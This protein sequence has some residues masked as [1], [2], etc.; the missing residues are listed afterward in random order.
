MQ[1]DNILPISIGI[2]IKSEQPQPAELPA[3]PKAQKPECVGSPGTVDLVAYSKWATAKCPPAACGT[4]TAAIHPTIE[5]FG[6]IGETVE[7]FMRGGVRLTLES[8]HRAKLIDEIG[9]VVFCAVWVLRAMGFEE[10][11]SRPEFLFDPA[12]TDELWENGLKVVLEAIRA[13][14]PER[15]TVAS[16][17][18]RMTVEP[19]FSLLTVNGGNAANKI[20][21]IAYQHVDVPKNQIVEL[22][23]GVISACNCILALHNVEF[24]EAIQANVNKL[25]ARFPEGWKPGGG[26]RE[27]S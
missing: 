12:E 5:L 7:H 21:K 6:E 17:K 25:D 1:D 11:L 15:I 18:Y 22:L 19:Y 23:L 14:T 3:E 4:P 8:D 2:G 20:K 16:A 24:F 9:D 27:K 13:K 10:A 26:V